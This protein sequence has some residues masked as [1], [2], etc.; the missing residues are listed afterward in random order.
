MLAR[1]PFRRLGILDDTGEDPSE[2]SALWRQCRWCLWVS[3]PS[4]GVVVDILP[5][6]GFRVIALARCCGLSSG[7]SQRYPLRDI[8]GKLKSHPGAAR[9]S[10]HPDVKLL[11]LWHRVVS[12]ASY[13]LHVPLV[14]PSLGLAIC[15]QDQ[16][17]TARSKRAGGPLRR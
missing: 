4:W 14:S 15:W 6:I 5:V 11:R 9:W 12:L 1:R 2:S 10:H 7:A 16:R 8:V 3:L 13:L 17:S